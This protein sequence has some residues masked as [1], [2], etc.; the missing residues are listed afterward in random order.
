MEKKAAKDFVGGKRNPGSGCFA[1]YKQDIH[2]DKFVI[3]HKY[4]EAK[5]FS[6]KKAYFKD[7]TEEAFKLGKLP[8]MVIEFV[9]RP[10]LKV[11]ILRYAD[12]IAL[13]R[14]LNE[15]NAKEDL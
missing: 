12:L 6:I 11:A 7:I 3:E 14:Y 10:E 8:A 13:D 5:S 2:S 9:D 15:E 1:N 4:T